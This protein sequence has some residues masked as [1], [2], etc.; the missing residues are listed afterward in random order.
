[1]GR[2]LTLQRS[3]VT[4]TDR[5]RYLERLKVRQA[6]YKSANCN[7]W[8]FEESGLPGAF[9]E[10]TEARDARTLRAAHAGAPETLLDPSRIYAEVE[11]S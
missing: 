9:I 11:L 10:F 2:V 3:L 6:Y 5:S 4:P 7:F 1:M 8:V